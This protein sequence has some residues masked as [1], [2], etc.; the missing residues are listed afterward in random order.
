MSY[1][2]CDVEYRPVGI[3]IADCHVQGDSFGYT[4]G[5]AISCL[6]MSA[7]GLKLTILMTIW[8]QLL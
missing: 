4:S 6:S 8:I 1:K 7:Y 3:V 2:F 5:G